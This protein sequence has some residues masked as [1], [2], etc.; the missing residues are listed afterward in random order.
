MLAA[1]SCLCG[2][3]EL[4]HRVV[5]ADQTFSPSQGYCGAFQFWFWRFGKWIEVVVD[6][7]LPTYRDKLVFMHSATNNEFWTPLLEKAYSK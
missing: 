7:R 4:L 3:P 5:P 2:R 1:V 6:D